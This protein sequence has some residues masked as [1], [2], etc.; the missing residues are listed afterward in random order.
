MD[1]KVRYDNT[2]LYIDRRM[3]DNRNK[4]KSIKKSIKKR[5]N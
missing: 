1:L 5:K 2:K 4:R 3:Q